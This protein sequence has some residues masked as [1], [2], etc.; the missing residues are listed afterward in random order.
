M[1]AT[2]WRLR[3]NHLNLALSSD[4]VLIAIRV[5]CIIH[6]CII[7]GKGV[8]CPNSDPILVLK[9]VFSKLG[10][11][12]LILCTVPIFQCL[13]STVAEISIGVPNFFGGSPSADPG[14]FQS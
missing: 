12:E 14:Q 10:K 13:A 6:S 2:P 7:R 1:R 4:D 8:V 5:Q 9:L 3:L 11:R